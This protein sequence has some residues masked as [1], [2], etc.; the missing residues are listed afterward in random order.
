M[1]QSKIT[2]ILKDKILEYICQADF[3]RNIYIELKT[4]L[5]ELNIEFNDLQAILSQFERLGFISNLNLRRNVTTFFLIVHV[6]ALD[7]KNRGGFLV[8]EYELKMKLEKMALEID[9][10]S[11]SFP[12]KAS[13]FTN[14][15]ADIASCLSLVTMFK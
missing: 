9:S 10:L 8:Y 1:N 12:E 11:K 14:I 7:F 5:S 4:I 6:D 3:E 15:A 2:P 13:V